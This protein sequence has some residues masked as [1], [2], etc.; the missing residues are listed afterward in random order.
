MENSG[1]PKLQ[2]PTLKIILVGASGVGKTCLIASYFKQSFDFQSIPTVAPAYSCSDVKRKDGTTVSLQIWD[3]A[4]QERYHSVSKLFFRD[5]GIAFICF[6]SGDE[7]STAEVP[8]WIKRVKEESPHC[9]FFFVLTKSDLHTSEEMEKLEKDAQ[10][11]FAEYNPKKIYV[12]SALSRDGVQELFNDAA[13]SFHPK[14]QNKAI[15]QDNKLSKDN[16][17]NKSSCRC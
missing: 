1:V 9:L 12:T 17:T 14:N 11:R 13:E 8:N 6:E 16:E 4:G 3:T 10:T 5:S 2:K 7:Q 15:I